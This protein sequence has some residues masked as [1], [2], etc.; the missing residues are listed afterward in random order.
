[1]KKDKLYFLTFLSIAVIFLFVALIASQYFIK[2][3]ANQ[4]IEVQVESGKR[5][6]NDIAQAVV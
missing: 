5:E 3:S 1:M 4:L 6:A 2:V